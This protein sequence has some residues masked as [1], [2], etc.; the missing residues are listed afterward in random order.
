MLTAD[1]RIQLECA[2]RDGP[3]PRGDTTARIPSANTCSEAI[4][5]EASGSALVS[6]SAMLSFSAAF[7][8]FSLRLKK[9]DIV[10]FLLFTL[11]WNLHA[12]VFWRNGPFRKVMRASSGRPM[13]IQDESAPAPLSSVPAMYSLGRCDG[14]KQHQ[15]FSFCFRSASA[16]K[17][18]RIFLMRTNIRSSRFKARK[19]M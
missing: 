5:V 19:I 8:S 4:V 15:A 18:S 1:T 17:T 10:P 6:C 3:T 11:S 12:A 7:L 2:C 9:R 13:R 14:R 16:V